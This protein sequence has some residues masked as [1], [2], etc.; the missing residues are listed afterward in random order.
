MAGRSS[1]DGN[2]RQQLFLTPSS[3]CSKYTLKPMGHNFTANGSGLC[4]CKLSLGP[5][6][7]ILSPPLSVIERLREGQGRKSGEA[8]RDLLL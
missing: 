4:S 3:L 7:Y 2:I 6:F 1:R 8:L 5:S